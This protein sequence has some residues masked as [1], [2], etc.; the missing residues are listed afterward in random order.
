MMR[1]S[2]SCAHKLL[3]AKYLKP[4]LGIINEIAMAEASRIWPESAETGKLGNWAGSRLGRTIQI[5]S[6]LLIAHLARCSRLWHYYEEIVA[7]WP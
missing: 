2:A 1:T 7:K 6:L 3:T 5:M 4:G